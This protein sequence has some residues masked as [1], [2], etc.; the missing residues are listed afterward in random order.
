MKQLK[1]ISIVWGLI[2]IVLFVTLTFFALKW[3]NQVYPYTELEEKLIT[4]TKKYYESKY[5]YPAAGESKYISLDELKENN[6]INSLKKDDDEC[7]GFVKVT[8]NNV[9]EYKSYIKCNNY[10][11]K[12]Y[13]KYIEMVYKK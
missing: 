4:T 3:K 11:T 5:Q 13:D 12:D 6:L 2:I 9:I 1:T 7:N 8:M 10:T